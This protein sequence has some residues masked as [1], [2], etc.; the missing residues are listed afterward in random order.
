[1]IAG[2]ARDKLSILGIKV[3][4]S[5]PTFFDGDYVETAKWGDM[6]ALAAP[7]EMTPL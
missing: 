2:V 1:M 4:V 5:E 7:F 3:T 6:E